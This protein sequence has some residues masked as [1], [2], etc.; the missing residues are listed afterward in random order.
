MGATYVGKS[1]VFLFTAEYDSSQ[2]PRVPPERMKQLSDLGSWD[3]GAG[4]M[5]AVA[6]AWNTVAI[7]VKLNNLT[8]N[9]CKLECEMQI[10]PGRNVQFHKCTQAI[11][12]VYT[13]LS[14]RSQTQP[15]AVFQRLT[16]GQDLRCRAWRAKACDN[17]LLL[18]KQ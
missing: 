5:W 2:K 4:W 13:P 11:I 16:Q 8:A 3:L 9:G 12:S 6:G 18:K 17:L 10:L 14:P 7:K 15:C 1:D